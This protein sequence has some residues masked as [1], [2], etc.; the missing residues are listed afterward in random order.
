M[1]KKIIVPLLLVFSL[2]SFAVT[3]E[4]TGDNTLT[5]DGETETITIGGQQYQ[6]WPVPKVGV[7]VFASIPEKYN[8]PMARLTPGESLTE[9]ELQKILE[10]HYKN[11]AFDADT[12]KVRNLSIAGPMYVAFCAET[13][14]FVACKHGFRAGMRIDLETNGKNRMGGMTG[15]EPAAFLVTKAG[16]GIVPQVFILE[17]LHGRATLATTEEL[18][19]TLDDGVTIQSDKPPADVMQAARMILA[20]EG[21]TVSSASPSASPLTTD[22]RALKIDSKIADCGKA[23]GFELINDKRVETNLLISVSDIGGQVHVQSAVGGVQHI[24]M[25][26]GPDKDADVILSCHSKGIIEKDI[27]EKL[28]A[29]LE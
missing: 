9:D 17:Q 16:T 20:S 8:G 22:A 25:P 18:K 12:F 26:F 4:K 11:S 14:P 28:L 19:K 7:E 6:L 3:F 2:P 23:M 1:M 10:I 5:T 24:S 21:Y 27:S 29:K 13:A 15:F